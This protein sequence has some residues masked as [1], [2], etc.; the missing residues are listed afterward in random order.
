MSTTKTQKLNTHFIDI[1]L[2]IFK[3]NKKRKIDDQY[4]RKTVMAEL[5]KIKQIAVQ[6]K[7]K[8]PEIVS[9]LVKMKEMAGVDSIDELI[10]KIDE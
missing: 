4:T 3:A 1:D 8:T 2:I 9:L 6:W 5:G 7:K 10:S